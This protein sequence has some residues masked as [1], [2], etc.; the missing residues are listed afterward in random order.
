MRSA[1]MNGKWGLG[2]LAISIGLVVFAC[3]D[4]GGPGR[5]DAGNDASAS[6]DASVTPVDARPATDAARIDVDG[7]GVPAP[8]DC[9]DTNAAI[10]PTAIEDCLTLLDEDCDG[11]G[12]ALDPDCD[13][14]VDE[15]DDEGSDEGDD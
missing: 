14:D 4:G 5:R 2:L 12:S 3:V 9:D 11:E 7:D 8:A 13:P 15:D 1:A 10:S 6:E